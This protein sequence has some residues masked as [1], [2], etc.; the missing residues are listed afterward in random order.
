MIFMKPEVSLSYSQDLRE[1]VLISYERQEGSMRE[2]AQ[3]F[4]IHFT[5]VHNWLKHY[6]ES[7][8]KSPRQTPRGRFSV[9]Q[10]EHQAF[11]EE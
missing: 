5:T 6:R 3:R 9:I 11:L 1:R 4:K 10:K 7:G 8:S 2:L